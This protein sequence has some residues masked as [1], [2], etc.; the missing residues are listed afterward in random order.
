MA[1]CVYSLLRLYRSC[2]VILNTKFFKIWVAV[3]AGG[4]LIADNPVP[5]LF[6][7][8]KTSTLKSLLKSL[9]SDRIREILKES[10]QK[11]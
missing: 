11:R 9:E 8:A 10:L 5:L 1:Y 7:L 4:N 6:F 2:I 3:D